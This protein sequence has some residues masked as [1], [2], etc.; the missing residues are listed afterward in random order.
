MPGDN[1]IPFRKRAPSEAQL[2]VYRRMTRNWSS[3]LKR[4]MFPEYFRHESAKASE[5]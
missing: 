3:E 2:E 5:E 1:V 4:L